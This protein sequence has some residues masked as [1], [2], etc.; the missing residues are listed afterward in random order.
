MGNQRGSPLEKKRKA[1]TQKVQREKHGGIQAIVIRELSQTIG[2]TEEEAQ[3][4]LQQHNNA[5]VLPLTI[6]ATRIRWV[7]VNGG[8]STD[9]LSQL[10][11]EQLSLIRND[12]KR[13]LTSL[14]GFSREWVGLEAMIDLPIKLGEETEHVG[15]ILQFVIVDGLIP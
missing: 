14:V 10:R 3:A 2:F 12:L 1:L 8:S 5:L 11:L 13:S 6:G 4:H 15:Q 7:L 9:V